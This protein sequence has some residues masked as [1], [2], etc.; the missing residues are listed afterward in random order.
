MNLYESLILLLQNQA[1]CGGFV[2]AGTIAANTT[3][4]Q[5]SWIQNRGNAGDTLVYE[6]EYGN[7]GSI[8]MGAKEITPARV[9]KLLIGTSASMYLIYFK[10]N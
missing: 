8:T 3:L 1:A 9:K 6:D 2:A 4:P 7:Q 10:L 5:P